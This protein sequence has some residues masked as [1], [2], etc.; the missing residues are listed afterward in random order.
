MQVTPRRM[1]LE[2][3]FVLGSARLGDFVGDTQFKSCLA[4]AR[5]LNKYKR[6]RRK[7]LR[8]VMAER[9]EED[10][11]EPPP[12]VSSRLAGAVKIAVFTVAEA[13]AWTGGAIISCYFRRHCSRNWRRAALSFGL[14]AAA[15]Y[16]CERALWTP[17]AKERELRRQLAAFAERRLRPVRPSLAAHCR[18]AAQKE[19]ASTLV[20][21]C[22]AA[23]GAGL[24]LGREA[25]RAAEDC[26]ALEA[27]AAA[28]MEAAEDTDVAREAL[29]KILEGN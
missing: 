9:R 6:L 22:G 5:V 7:V 3:D 15:A 13:A 2:I 10:D 25:R 1:P 24:E 20:L 26:A 28:A 23:E 14:A 11:G 21:A 16:A 18:A 19:L 27:A 4:P 12:S 29:L 17:A 8:R